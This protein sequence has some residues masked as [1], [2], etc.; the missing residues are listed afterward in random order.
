[1]RYIYSTLLISFLV[2]CGSGSSGGSGN[3]SKKLDD[4]AYVVVD[5]GTLEH[6][7]TEVT[8]Q[9]SLAFLDPTKD[10]G[11]SYAWAGTINDGGSITL[12]AN[13]EEGL[14]NGIEVK[15][16]RAVKVLS[17][18][19]TAAGEEIDVSDKFSSVDAAAELSFQI[20]VHNDESPAAHVLIWTADAESFDG[21]TAT[22]NSAR[23]TAVPGQG[24]GNIWGFAL[25]DA[26]L[27]TAAVSEPKF[28]DEEE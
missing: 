19:I 25:S 13:A 6:N 26:T 9:G 11:N 20:D 16:S 15:F 14:K 12:Y 21:D 2:A 22:F 27:S 10:K 23:D 5:A 7:S 3:D 28:E 1:M 8:G 4:A 24:S 17:V 18:A